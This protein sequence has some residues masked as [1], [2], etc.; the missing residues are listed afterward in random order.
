MRPAARAR[1]LRG[2]PG[3]FDRIC[4]ELIPQTPAYDSFVLSFQEP[5]AQVGMVIVEQAVADLEALLFAGLDRHDFECCAVLHERERGCDVHYAVGRLNLRTGQPTEFHNISRPDAALFARFSSA[6]SLRHGLTDPNDP[7][8]VN[9]KTA[10]PT[11]LSAEERLIWED[12]DETA[13]AY[14]LSG[15]ASNRD[16]LIAALRR[17][18]HEARACSKTSLTIQHADKSYTFRGPKYSAGFQFDL[19]ADP[20]GHGPD[21]RHGGLRDAGKPAARTA[22]V[23]DELAR[24]TAERRARQQT[25]YGHA[26]GSWR[27]IG[28]GSRISGRKRGEVQSPGLCLRFPARGGRPVGQP[29]RGTPAVAGAILAS[30]PAGEPAD[31]LGHHLSGHPGNQPGGMD[32]GQEDA[33]QGST[34]EPL[35]VAGD[36]GSAPARPDVG[37]GD[38][39]DLTSAVPSAPRKGFR[40]H[41]DEHQKKEYITLSVPGTYHDTVP[42][43]D[44]PRV[45]RRRLRHRQLGLG[46]VAQLYEQ[47]YRAIQDRSQR[48]AKFLAG[49]IALIAVCGRAVERACRALA[50]SN[51][52][53]SASCAAVGAAPQRRGIELSFSGCNQGVARRNEPALPRYAAEGAT[54]HAQHDGGAKPAQAGDDARSDFKRVAGQLGAVT[55]SLRESVRTRRVGAIIS[56]AAVPYTPEMS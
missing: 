44:T 51:R 41:R 4:R 3:E 32:G 50:A 15:D 6:F 12:F 34:R 26:E 11:D 55:A 20:V 38:T 39:I 46:F 10:A 49:A 18:G 21:G 24:L 14:Y 16:Q 45:L 2:A 31:D 28:K 1:P 30:A 40:G 23:E 19:A 53:F 7:R 13:I 35:A 27:P 52:L 56:R 25:N 9:L 54:A 33:S 8:R 43:M 29:D 22:R 48:V 47:I 17:E 42:A 5:T 36:D 37:S